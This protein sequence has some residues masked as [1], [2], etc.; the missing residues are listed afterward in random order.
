MSTDRNYILV[1]NIQV[2]AFLK[3]TF[4]IKWDDE[5]KFWYT[6]N[7]DHYNHIHMKPFHIVNYAVPYR[8]KEEAKTHGFRWNST[9]KTWVACKYITIRCPVFMAKLNKKVNALFEG[10]LTA[11]DLEEDPDEPEYDFD[12]IPQ[13]PRNV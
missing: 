13:T 9:N 4:D 3:D 2:K 12:D 11:K 10:I 8:L 5:T 7:I 6:T 1:P